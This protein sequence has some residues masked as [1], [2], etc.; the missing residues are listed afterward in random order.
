MLGIY[1]TA[2]C[3]VNGPLPVA[4]GAVPGNVDEM[5]PRCSASPI[6]LRRQEGVVVYKV[7]CGASKYLGRNPKLCRNR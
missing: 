2:T 5:P 6:W 3:R 4:A 7:R 1:S